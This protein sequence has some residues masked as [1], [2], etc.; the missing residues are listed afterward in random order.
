LTKPI[1]T[2][3]TTV[4]RHGR[5]DH[6]Q[7][8]DVVND[9]RLNP[10]VLLV[11][12]GD[13]RAAGR[14]EARLGNRPRFDSRGERMLQARTRRNAFRRVQVFEVDRIW[15]VEPIRGFGRRCQGATRAAIN[16]VCRRAGRG[17]D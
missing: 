13:R 11:E 14:H 10:V 5:R 1:Q 6:G 15:D 3:G 4:T 9:C 17:G 12:L 16:Q 2:Q 7:R 8:E